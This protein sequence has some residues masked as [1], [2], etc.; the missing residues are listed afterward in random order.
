LGHQRRFKRKPRTSAYPPIATNR[1]TK[2]E[3]RRM[4]ANFAKLPEIDTASADKRGVTRLQ[5]HIHD[6]PRNVRLAPQLRKYHC[7]ALSVATGQ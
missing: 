5:S 4:A 6:S 7:N 2:H 3:A 1:L